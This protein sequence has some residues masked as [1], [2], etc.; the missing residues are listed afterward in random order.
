MGLWFT[1]RHTPNVGITI[2]CRR[3]LFSKK[4]RFQQID[5]LETQEFGRML[6]LDG[7]VMTT[8]R[9]EFIY[10]E[11]LI[12]PAMHIHKCAK[13]ALVIGGGDGGAIR[14]LCRYPF[15]EEIVLCEIDREVVE[16][17]KK[18]L[19]QISSRLSD[20]R[21]KL[22]FEDGAEF[23]KDSGKFDVIFV[24]STDPIGAAKAL[25]S[26]EFYRLCQ[27][28]LAPGGILVAQSESPFYHLEIIKE[29][30]RDVISAGFDTVRFYTAPIPTYPGGYWSW[31]L[32]SKEELVIKRPGNILPDSEYSHLNYYNLEVHEAAFKLPCFFKRALEEIGL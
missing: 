19:P 29:M 4:S 20:K 13:R 31:L 18:Y 5:C 9:D 1:E 21:V 10:H 24:D 8:E 28:R 32:A 27:K 11:M 6:L 26:I 14:E 16:C 30:A 25:F 12:H 17:S 22:V 23:L 2:K 3:T 15:L 7:L